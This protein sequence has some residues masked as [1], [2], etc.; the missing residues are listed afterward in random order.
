VHSLQPRCTPLPNQLHTTALLCRLQVTSMHEQIGAHQPA[1][2]GINADI[3]ECG[4]HWLATE[5]TA[6]CAPTEPVVQPLYTLTKGAVLASIATASRHELFLQ[7]CFVGPS[8]LSISNHAPHLC[9]VV[10][11]TVSAD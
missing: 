2:P 8:F 5:P 3:A 11:I 4:H 7:A 9:F 1:A 6:C 10:V